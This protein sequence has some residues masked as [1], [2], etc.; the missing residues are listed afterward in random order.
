MFLLMIFMILLL[1]FVPKTLFTLIIF[2]KL[3]LFFCAQHLVY[4]QYNP[5]SILTIKINK[6]IDTK[7][8]KKKSRKSSIHDFFGKIWYLKIW[9]IF[10]VFF[11]LLQ[12]FFA[13]FLYINVHK[14]LFIMMIFN[15][16]LFF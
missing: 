12:T 1:I 11:R 14:I 13:K 4:Y 5:Y 3:F 6:L 2:I 15:I 9:F 8:A 7:F 16:W 10:M